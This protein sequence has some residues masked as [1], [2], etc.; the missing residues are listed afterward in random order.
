MAAK[1]E[2]IKTEMEKVSKV[3]YDLWIKPLQPIGYNKE[4]QTIIL[5]TPQ[6]T[7]IERL[8]KHSKMLVKLLSENSKVI[9]N[10]VIK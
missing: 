6:K 7:A 9:K 4:L 3:D 1:L 8:E 5:F 10:F 2:Q